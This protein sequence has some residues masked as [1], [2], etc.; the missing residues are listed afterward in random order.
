VKEVK[1]NFI[2]IELHLVNGLFELVSLVLNH[3]FSFLD[4]FLLLLKLLYLFVYLLF[5]H[6]EEILM[7]YFKLV[8][9]PSKG[10]L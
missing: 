4:F 5:H 9:D 6:L 2:L 3:F 7:L 1:S 8:H 10:F